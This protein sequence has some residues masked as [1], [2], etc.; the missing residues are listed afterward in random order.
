MKVSYS[1]N[2]SD[3]LL[4]KIRVMDPSRTNLD[5]MIRDLENQAEA[6]KELETKSEMMLQKYNIL[7]K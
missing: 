3:E 4:A 2:L 7:L 5:A 1:E 6:L